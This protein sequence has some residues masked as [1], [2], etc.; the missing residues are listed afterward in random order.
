MKNR[1]QE[2]KTFLGSGLVLSAV[3][4][5]GSFSF[6]WCGICSV[7]EETQKKERAHLEQVLNQSAAVCYAL[8]GR[9]PESL[10]YLKEQYGI[11][12]NEEQYL[13]DFERIGANLPPD[14]TVIS[15]KTE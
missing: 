11:C 2:K 12:W 9:Y 13:V 4:M 5:A 8:E 10:I 7:Q 15:R 1:F 6:F 3:L 14:I